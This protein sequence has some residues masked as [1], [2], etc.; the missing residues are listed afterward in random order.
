MAVSRKLKEFYLRFWDIPET[1]TANTIA[2]IQE[3]KKLKSYTSK[4]KIKLTREQKK[5]IRDFWKP[6]ARISTDWA[7]FHYAQNGKFDPKYFPATIYFTKVDQHFN[8]RKLGS[9]FNDKN[10]YSRIF[11]DI[12]QPKTIVRK[13]GGLLYD[14]NYALID[15]ETA[16]S[17]IM[18]EED[19]ITKPSQESGSGRGIIFWKTQESEKEI[20]EFLTDDYERDYIIQGIVNQHPDLAK[21]HPSSLNTVRIATIMFPEG[22]YILSSVYRMGVSGSRVDNATAGG[23]SVG[24][25]EDGSLKKIGYYVEG[26]PTESHPDGFVFDGAKIPSYDKMVETVKKAAQ[27]I[28]NFRLVS[29]DLS[30]SPEGEV[31]LIESNMRKGG[32]RIHQVDNGALFGEHTERVLKEIYKK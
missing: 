12:A 7:L 9:G 18:A 5:E 13:I 8:S 1:F 20:R 15:L 29:W 21:P 19:V 11:P 16:V 24:I 23:V 17:K 10:Y 4:L 26:N 25:N 31:I 3:L 27:Y 2:R 6:Y 32:I 28:G 14:E 22:V 30:V